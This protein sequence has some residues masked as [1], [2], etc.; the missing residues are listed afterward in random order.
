MPSPLFRRAVPIAA[1]VATGAMVGAAIPITRM[2]NLAGAQT[3][4]WAFASTGAAAALLVAA[5]TLRGSPIRGG[6]DHLVYY[7]AVGLFSIALPQLLLA[8]VVPMIGAGLA[9][10]GY[11]LPPILTLAIT[12]LVGTGRPSAR[13]IA[14]F[15]LGLG[16]ALLV[17]LPRGH[18]PDGVASGWVAL[19]MA[20]PLSV[21]I[22]NVLRARIWPAGSVPLANA[23]GAMGAG[24]AMLGLVAA[25]GGGLADLPSVPIG[26]AL[27]HAAVSAVAFVLFFVLQAI[28][29]PVYTSQV[30]YI[31]TVVSLATG[32]LVFGEAI[33]AMAYAAAALIAAGVVL[34]ST[35]RRDT[36]KP[37]EA[38]I[39]PADR[40]PRPVG[41]SA[42]ST[43]GR[44]VRP[45]STD[46]ISAPL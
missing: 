37:I 41:A 12:A 32:A 20:V 1:L 6:V 9:G 3:L 5:A 39:D 18:L 27:A 35:G 11:T 31:A 14:G 34:V 2:A 8:L 33:P 4:S 25:V 46:R 44:Q 30:G 7:G 22:G 23:A 38:A 24:A 13:C 10:I 36:G 29:G 45:P 15:V 17:V 42:Q 40:S 43:R 28:A 19:G 26:L 16:G 21:A